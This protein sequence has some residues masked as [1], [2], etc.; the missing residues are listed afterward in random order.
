M[1]SSDVAPLMWDESRRREE[2]EG[3]DKRNKNWWRDMKEVVVVGGFA[4]REVLMISHPVSQP[5]V[6]FS[7]VGGWITQKQ[8]NSPELQNN[9]IGS[10]RMLPVHGWLII[11][12]LNPAIIS[13]VSI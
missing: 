7:R 3:E 12:I 4:N 8:N 11:R 9:L 10:A 2:E 1:E 5:R 13:I 6:K